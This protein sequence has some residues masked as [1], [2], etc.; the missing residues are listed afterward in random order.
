MIT[1]SR[2]L[3]GLL[4]LL[5]LVAVF[6]WLGHAERSIWLNAPPNSLDRFAIDRVMPNMPE[7]LP[8]EDLSRLCLPRPWWMS[9]LERNTTAACLDGSLPKASGDRLDEL[10]LEWADAI[11]GQIL[12]AHNVLLISHE[13]ALP[14]FN[15]L[16]SLHRRLQDESGGPVFQAALHYGLLPDRQS[17]PQMEEAGKADTAAVASY[18]E[19]ALE[20][21]EKRFWHLRSALASASDTERWRLVRELGLLA[22]GRMLEHDNARRVPAPILAVDR[23]VLAS[24]LERM[25]RAAPRAREPL[26][27]MLTGF[28]QTMTLSAGVAVAVAA[29]LRAAPMLVAALFLLATLGGLHLL[30]IAVTGPTALRHLPTRDFV[31]GFAGLWGAGGG[32]LWGPAV[33][34][35][36]ALAVSR[37]ASTRPGMNTLLRIPIPHAVAGMA[38]LFATALLVP[39]SPAL[40]TEC[41]NFIAASAVALWVARYVPSIAQGASSWRLSLFAAPVVVAAFSSGFLGSFSRV[42]PLG[43]LGVAALVMLIL[44]L[45]L[46]GSWAIRGGVLILLGLGLWAYTH[47]LATGNDITGLIAHL[48]RHGVQRFLAAFDSLHHGAPDVRQVRWLIASA[49]WPGDTGSGWGWGNVPWRGLPGNSPSFLPVAAVSDLSFAL[50]AAVGGV[51]YGFALMSVVAALLILLIH[52]G[53]ALAFGDEARLAQRFFACIGAIGLTIAL[54]R[55]IVNLAGSLQ[56]LPLAGVPIALFAHAPAANAFILVY[57]GLVLGAGARPVPRR[58]S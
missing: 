1:S 19:T 35:V 33:V 11:N 18:V 5:F 56:L 34:F 2:L 57:A 50:V 32:M 44:S 42:D 25:R 40:R 28:M 49:D 27:R 48:P 51:G 23:A 16:R 26:D 15:S 58:L 22:T 29:I 53:F 37:F 31:E 52:R 46:A 55:L 54:L 13:T 10:E 4:A 38:G 43:S 14:V 17:A 41:L 36:A 20:T 3:D 47:F 39:L 30:D 9:L 6:L 45:I 12:F 7:R 21:T 8:A 24:S